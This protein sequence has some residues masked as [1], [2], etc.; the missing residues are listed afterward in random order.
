VVWLAADAAALVYLWLVA[1]QKFQH[2]VFYSKG[3]PV[4]SILLLGSPLDVHCHA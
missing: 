3:A 1:R 4:M 2:I